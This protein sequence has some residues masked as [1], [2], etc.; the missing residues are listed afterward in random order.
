M[1]EVK[2]TNPPEDGISAVKFA[3]NSSQFVLVSSWD[4]SVRLYD[5]NEN[6][7]RMK[8]SHAAPVLDCCFQVS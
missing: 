4:S 7:M 5:V 6:F 1:T 3:P 8:Y 2:L